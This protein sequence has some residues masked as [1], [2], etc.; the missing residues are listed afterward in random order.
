M[1]FKIYQ[2]I[3]NLF[4]YYYIQGGVFAKGCTIESVTGD[5]D[6]CAERS[7]ILKAIR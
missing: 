2:I 1:Y 6:I 7:A 4:I 5:I 3:M